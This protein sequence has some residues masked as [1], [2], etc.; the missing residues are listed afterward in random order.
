MGRVRQ[1]VEI[2]P[3]TYPPR[4]IRGVVWQTQPIFRPQT[5]AH[6]SA[7][8]SSRNLSVNACLR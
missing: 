1:W 8:E 3:T 4:P 2:I 6:V 5:N 7:I